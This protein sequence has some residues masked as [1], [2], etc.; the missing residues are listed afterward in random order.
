[1]TNIFN[2]QNEL[3]SILNEIEENEGELTLELEEK[4]NIKQNEFKDKIK[5]YSNVIKMLESDINLIKEEKNRLSELQKAKEKTI[6]RIKKII[7]YAIET[8]GDT[9]K[10]GNKFV[11]YGTGKISIKTTQAIEVE[12]ESVTRFINRII[13]GLKWYADNNQLTSNLLTT[14]DILSFV[15]TKSPEEEENGIEIDNFEIKDIERLNASI[16][17][18]VNLKELISTEEGIDLLKGLLEHNVFKIKAKPDK[19]GIK[20]D[21]KS[22]EHYLPCYAKIVENKSVIIK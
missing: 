14:E 10:S 13:T 22:E 18:D 17:L 5:S 4:L 2:I 7:V 3:L 8:F 16:D 21:A 6:E 9:T 19:K 20:D 11:D 12:E 1:M 15:N